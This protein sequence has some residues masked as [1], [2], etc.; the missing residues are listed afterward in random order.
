[1][2]SQLRGPVQRGSRLQ[3][4]QQTDLHQP[5]APQ[6]PRTDCGPVDPAVPPDAAGPARQA[7]QKGSLLQGL[8]TDLLRELRLQTDWLQQL[9]LRTG[10][11]QPPAL[12]KPR[13]G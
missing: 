10:T 7:L 5:Q 3:E 8:Q 4:P 6:G 2:G 12:R 9:G 1:M 13:T 11:E